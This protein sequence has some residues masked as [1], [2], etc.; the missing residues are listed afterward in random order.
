MTTPGPFGDPAPFHA[1]VARG[2]RAGHALWARTSDGVRIRLGIW[3][4]GRKGTVLLFPGRT[5][6]IEKYGTVAAALQDLGYATLAVDWRGQGLADRALP[7][8]MSG[9]VADFADYQRDVACM[10]E[11]ARALPARSR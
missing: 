11:A 10:L 5:E 3:P 6:Y 1:D 7:D 2:P 8:R 9:H 4:E